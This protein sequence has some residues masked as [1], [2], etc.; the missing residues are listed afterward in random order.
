[1][2]IFVFVKRST[3]ARQCLILF[4]LKVSCTSLSIPRSNCTGGFP[5]PR[6]TRRQSL[7][8][9][10][11][12]NWVAIKAAPRPVS[13]TRPSHNRQKSSGSPS[14]ESSRPTSETGIALS[15]GKATKTSSA[16]TLPSHLSMPRTRSL[17]TDC[18]RPG[19]LM[20]TL[21]ITSGLNS[22]HSPSQPTRGRVRKQR[23]SRAKLDSNCSGEVQLQP[24]SNQWSSFVQACRGPCQ[25]W[26]ISRKQTF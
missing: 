15:P 20:P 17:P 11:V 26:G 22:T 1:M 13:S 14:S 23:G 21:R 25:R 6:T 4:T 8:T 18:S 24:T 2:I 3:L 12:L 16:T 5:G 10:V 19:A 9:K 7:A